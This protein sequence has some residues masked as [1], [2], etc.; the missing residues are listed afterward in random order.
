MYTVDRKLN[1]SIANVAFGINVPL[2]PHSPMLAQELFAFESLLQHWMMGVGGV[3]KNKTAE[4]TRHT[5]TT[6]SF[7]VYGTRAAVLYA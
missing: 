6:I 7:P 4:C 2:A 3:S 1:R 5:F